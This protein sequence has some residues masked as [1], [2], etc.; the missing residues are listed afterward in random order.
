[1]FNPSRREKAQKKFGMENEARK[2]VDW[3]RKINVEF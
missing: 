1:M 2:R 3:R